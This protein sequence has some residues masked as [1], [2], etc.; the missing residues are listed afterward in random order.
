MSRLAKKGI[1]I[2]S[3]VEVKLDGSSVVVKGSK[4]E[5]AR[6]F[7]P[8]VKIQVEGQLIKLEPKGS[9]KLVRSLVGT[10]AAHLKN[11]ILGVTEGFAKK[12]Q[13]EGTGYRFEVSGKELNLSVGFSH[14]V[15]LSIPEELNLKAEKGELTISGLDKELV[16]QFA[17]SVRQ[18]RPPEPYKGKGIRY[19]GEVIRRKQGKRAVA[20]AV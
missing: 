13:I 2:P 15:K 4:G 8:E 6:F 3:G 1:Q 19:E 9:S 18:V 16:G 20:T 7:R 11:M 5:L 14:P 12:L 10:Y 17:A